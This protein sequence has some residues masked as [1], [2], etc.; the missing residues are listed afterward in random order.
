MVLEVM[1]RRVPSMAGVLKNRQPP[2]SPALPLHSTLDH[3]TCRWPISAQ[4]AVLTFQAPAD[5]PRLSVNLELATDL[6]A[7]V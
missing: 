1:L 5:P 4:P 6:A 7:K 2:V 3:V